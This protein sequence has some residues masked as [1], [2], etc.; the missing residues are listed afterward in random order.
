MSEC[1]LENEPEAPTTTNS[2]IY[3]YLRLQKNL[4]VG[5]SSVILKKLTKQE[6]AVITNNLMNITHKVSNHHLHHDI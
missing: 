4:F 6:S 1:S 3:I 5:N 2:R